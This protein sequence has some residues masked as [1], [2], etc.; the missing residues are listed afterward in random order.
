[1]NNSHEGRVPPT[2]SNN[3]Q[4]GT[5]VISVESDPSRPQRTQVLA[6]TQP[7]GP[8]SAPPGSSNRLPDRPHFPARSSTI[9]SLDLDR[10]PSNYDVIPHARSEDLNHTSHGISYPLAI[11]GSSPKPTPAS[12]SSSSRPP[13]PAA[14]PSSSGHSD[15]SDH[16]LSV[17]SFSSAHSGSSSYSS[18]PRAGPPT[19]SSTSASLASSY[20]SICIR[21]MT[22][23]FC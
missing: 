5:Q 6:K 23:K 13:T 8:N 15:S 19:S 17:A 20:V 3:Q 16:R 1:M 18:T 21:N 2:W 14:N 4:N 9:G 7:N 22:R 10:H 12:N 11:S